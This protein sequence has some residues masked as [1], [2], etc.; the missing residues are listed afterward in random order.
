MAE[1]RLLENVRDAQRRRGRPAPVSLPALFEAPLRAVGTVPEL[2]PYRRIRREPVLGPL[3][4]MPPH[5]PPPETPRLFAYLGEEHPGLET[6]VQALADVPGERE[7]YLRGSVGLLRRFLAA[8]GVKVHEAPPPLADA[9]S[10]ASVVVS[11][12]GSTT[13]H[14]ALIAGRP[15]VLFPTHIEADLTADALV[16]LQVGVKLAPKADA[17]EIKEAIGA[18]SGRE[19]RDDA[20]ARALSAASARRPDGAAAAANACLQ[21]LS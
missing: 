21:L 16:A 12:A 19:F 15:Q 1:G 13:A 3:E 20:S 11:H 2:D 10:R 5:S 14:A 7:A 4:E 18:A 8:R 17:A 6:I 9:V